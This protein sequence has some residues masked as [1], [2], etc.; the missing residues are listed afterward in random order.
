MEAMGALSLRRLAPFDANA[1]V[2]N[3]AASSPALAKLPF[4]PEEVL[5]SILASS[6]DVII[7]LDAD[8]RITFV[9]R[10]VQGLTPADVVGRSVYDFVPSE[11][12][13]E[14]RRRFAEVRGSGRAAAYEFETRGKDGER[15]VY[16]TRCIPIRHGEEVTGDLLFMS[17]DITARAL[18]A[19]KQRAAEAELARADARYRELFHHSPHPEWV[20][21][22]ETLCLLDVNET[23]LKEYGFT[24]EEFLALTI[25]DLRPAEDAPRL[26]AFLR[27]AAA[28]LR[29][30]VWRHRRKD[31]SLID[32]DVTGRPI[33]FGDRRARL[34]VA[35]D[36]TAHQRLIET[37]AESEERHRLLFQASP[38]PMWLS[39]RETLR[40]VDVNDAALRLYGYARAEFLAL[41]VP[42]VQ[43]EGMAAHRKKD[44]S[45]VE[46]EVHQSEVTLGGRACVFAVVDDV[47]EKKR[48]ERQLVQAQ[49][50]EA[51]GQ[52]AGGVAHD[53]NNILAV[54]LVDGDW[55]LDELGPTHPLRED[56]QNICAA[57]QRA[58]ALTRQLLAF[59]RRQILQ[60]QVLLLNDVVSDME[61]MLVR[62]LP[63]D[64]QVRVA[65][66]ER[67]GSVEAD[68][69]QI[70]QVLMNLAVNA[71][72]AM[73][74]GGKLTLETKNVEVDS[75]EAH[76][77][78]DVTPGR[79]VMLGV[80]DTGQGMDEATLAR[81]FEPFFT[82]KDHGKGTGLGLSTVFGIVKQS[83]GGIAVHS[84][85]GGGTSF[86][87]VLPRVDAARATPTQG[88]RTDGSDASEASCAGTETI[89]L[90][91]Y[92][93]RVRASV[94]RILRGQG[95]IVCEASSGEAALEIVLKRR[96]PFDLVL[97]DIVM[98]GIDG[99]T[100]AVR[101][102]EHHPRT[103]VVYMSGYAELA[104]LP[105]GALEPGMRFVHKPFTSAQ[106]MLAVRAALDESV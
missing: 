16:E 105:G 76:E 21:D 91:E 1:L 88:P 14:R 45:L 46:A 50:M 104:T 106:L 63:A 73:P 79:Y 62:L 32:V 98:P 49:K 17:T 80:S 55:M 2:S 69:G 77:L 85:M 86:K 97:S 81:I 19:E 28:E 67:L 84:R 103:R 7:K 40:F 44:G 74:S 87:I 60:P 52:L 4:D 33:M 78:G 29:Q 36:V 83:G 22:E 35:R 94:A 20:F 64:I 38:L 51:I 18:A 23:A 66:E 15:I 92:D 24:R 9:N 12:R 43:P 102:R 93:A 53:F 70:E 30:S 57:A 96:T 61:K 13:D 27:E 90:V 100:T 11:L 72:D 82:T 68:R 3:S 5:R 95:Y 8:D 89:L 6:P 54:I 42:D 75:K 34:V 31:G 99:P 71:R 10:P 39:D 65:R 56:V 101:I 58:A 47:T 59:S 41:R 25:A 48:L 26:R 37:L